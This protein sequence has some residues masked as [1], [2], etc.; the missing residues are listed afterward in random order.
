[1][2]T[3][4]ESDAVNLCRAAVKRFGLI[5]SRDAGGLLIDLDYGLEQAGLL[6]V[7]VKKTGEPDCCLRVTAHYD[8]DA[9]ETLRKILL[10]LEDIAYDSDDAAVAYVVEA[11]VVRV[12]FLT[13]AEEIG[14]ATV[15]LRATPRP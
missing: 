9:E 12:S 3:V 6:K 15:C 8:G 1:M 13:Q 5:R 2:K 4:S 7:R 10:V 11:G 14:A